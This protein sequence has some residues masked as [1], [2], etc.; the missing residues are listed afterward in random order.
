M[1]LKSFP[2]NLHLS[3]EQFNPSYSFKTREC[4]RHGDVLGLFNKGLEKVIRGA[5][6]GTKGNIFNKPFQ[7][8]AYLNDVDIVIRIVQKS[9]DYS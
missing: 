6:L 5:K 1:Y 9:K 2:E 7:I 4:V 3:V 8:L